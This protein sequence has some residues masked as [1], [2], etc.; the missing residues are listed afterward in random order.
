MAADCIDVALNLVNTRYAKESEGLLQARYPSVDGHG[1]LL[2]KIC[3]GEAIHYN[4]CLYSRTSSMSVVV[5]I[6]NNTAWMMGRC[7]LLHCLTQFLP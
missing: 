6:G 2:S 5:R 1:G 3:A 7:N 4:R